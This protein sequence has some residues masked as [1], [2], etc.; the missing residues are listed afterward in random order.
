METAQKML[1]RGYQIDEICEITGLSKE[2][3][4][5]LRKE[6]QKPLQRN[7]DDRKHRPAPLNW[8]K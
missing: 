7:I 1:E 2:E 5:K 8:I 6:K 4:E 3:I